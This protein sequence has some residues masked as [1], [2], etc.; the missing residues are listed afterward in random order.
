MQAILQVQLKVTARD[1][2]QPSGLQHAFMT[3]MSQ[4][5]LAAP[6]C[7]MASWQHEPCRYPYRGTVSS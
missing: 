3:G 6:D 1:A 4:K 5:V 2:E 7:S